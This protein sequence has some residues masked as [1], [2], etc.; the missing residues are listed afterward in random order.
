MSDFPSP[1]PDFHDPLGLLAACHD[2]ILTHCKLLGRIAEHHA[3]GELGASVRGACAQ[4]T[5]YFTTASVHHHEDEEH[6]LFP[7]LLRARPD[8][9]PLVT[10]LRE[11]HKRLEAVWKNLAPALA[12]P[13]SYA[14]ADFHRRV[15]EFRAAY[16]NHVALENADLI[17]AA[18]KLLGK[19]D[20]ARLGQAMAHRRGVPL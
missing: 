12:D 1:A 2:R 9:A 15:D 20:L 17:P 18:Q 7:L 11:E 8:L 5:R 3:R 14:T 13:E 6:D 19:D 10:R 16:E 4:V